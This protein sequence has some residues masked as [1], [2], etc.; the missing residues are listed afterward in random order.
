M[1]AEGMYESPIGTA[2]NDTDFYYANFILGCEVKSGIQDIT[3]LNTNPQ[4]YDYTAY[5][6]SANISEA[7]TLNFSAYSDSPYETIFLNVNQEHNFSVVIKSS[8]GSNRSRL[9]C[10]WRIGIKRRCGKYKIYIL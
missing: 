7:Q 4:T 5:H 2:T 1:S 10:G 6:F 8:R 9:V 3:V